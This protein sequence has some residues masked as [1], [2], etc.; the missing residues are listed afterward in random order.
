MAAVMEI[1][2]D[3]NHPSFYIVRAL[4]HLHSF[5]TQEK[6]Q[7]GVLFVSVQCMLSYIRTCSMKETSGTWRST[8][9]FIIMYYIELMFPFGLTDFNTLYGQASLVTNCRVY[10]AV[11]LLK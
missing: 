8:N 10:V 1:F 2:F 7:L 4:D 9:Y 5:Y 6:P 11:Q 3:L